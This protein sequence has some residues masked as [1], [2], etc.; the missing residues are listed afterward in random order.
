MS[1]ILPAVSLVNGI[2]TVSSLDVAER[3]GKQHKN[4]LRDIER[5]I[6]DLPTDFNGLN[7]APV[8]Y[9]DGKG[10][11]RPMYY[12]TRDAFSLLAMGFTGKKALV[13]KVKYIEAF[14][15]M[16]AEL[17]KK[18]EAKTSQKKVISPNAN[19]S[20]GTKV[21]N[22]ENLRSRI[23][24][25]LAQMEKQLGRIYNLAKWHLSPSSADSGFTQKDM[26][27]FNTLL[28]LNYMAMGSIYTAKEALSIAGMMRK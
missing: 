25:E 14:N 11:K 8:D 1:D 6:S 12:L 17:L 7:F 19:K 18:D 15:L 10:E 24:E 22:G 3:F 26:D 16:E 28:H 9:T 21:D 23:I 27:Y 4:V 2:P 20:G 5:L 13:W